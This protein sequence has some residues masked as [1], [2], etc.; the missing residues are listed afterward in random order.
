MIS[1]ERT[2]GRSAQ[3]KIKSKQTALEQKRDNLLKIECQA[4]LKK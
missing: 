4:H 2:R 1:Q 3:S